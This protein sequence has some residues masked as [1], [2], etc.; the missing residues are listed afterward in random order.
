METTAL[1]YFLNELFERYRQNVPDVSLVTEKLIE[2]G[3]VGS[4]NEIVND[5][6]A[7]RTLGVQHLGITSFERIFLTNGYQKMDYL[8]F[9]EKK[10]NAYWY[11]PP[12]RDFPRVFIS[13]LRVNELSEQAQKIIAKYTQSIKA[14]PLDRCDLRDGKAISDFLHSPLWQV[15]TLHEYQVL[16]KESEYAA[17]VIYNRYYLNHY[18]I[19]VHELP[20]GYN[21]LEDFNAFLKAIGIKLNTSGGEIKES[22]DGLLR[23]SSS[24]SEVKTATFSC[25]N[26]LKIAGSYV[27]FAERKVLPQF[28]NLP[29]DQ[30]RSEHRREGFEARNADKIFE[31]TYSSQTGKKK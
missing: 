6:I 15:P 17:W 8:N 26:Q 14:D 31:S 2:Q 19:S 22:A 11:K 18:T 12:S 30:I 3:V 20:V 1:Q 23:Q 28:S 13:E 16:M 5:H 25:G 29:A 9:P 24:I 21:R 10:L 7:F 4:Q 27:E